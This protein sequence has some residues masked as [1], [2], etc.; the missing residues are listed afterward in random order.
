MTNHFFF[1]NFF[2][3]LFKKTS[4]NPIKNWAGVLD[5][6]EDTQ[7]HI[8]PLKEQL[9]SRKPHEDDYLFFQNFPHCLMLDI[10]A[11]A[12][13][14]AISTYT[15]NKK[16]DVISFEPNVLLKDI[17][18]GVKDLIPNYEYHMFG[19]SSKECIT[20]LYIPVVDNAYITPLASMNKSIY[21]REQD[22]ARLKGFSE[23][24]T[25]KI[26]TIKTQFKRLDSLNL[27]PRIIK[28]DAEE[29]ELEILHGGR[30]TLLKQKPALMIENNS[31]TQEIDKY[32]FSLDY[33]KWCYDKKSNRLLKHSSKT[34]SC[35]SFYIY[36]GDPIL[37]KYSKSF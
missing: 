26:A 11:N 33:T 2:S 34:Q 29:A 6:T 25:F 9:K 15:V 7:K 13:S 4:H 12:G 36:R 27:A 20:N 10:G 32:L 22:K 14:S 16:I 24:G 5:L 28:I 19:L 37:K 35:N 3:T 17:L 1:R 30:E 23:N 18:Q 21:S 31:K 8:Q